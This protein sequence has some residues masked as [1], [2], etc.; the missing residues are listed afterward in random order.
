MRK[1]KAFCFQEQLSRAEIEQ[2][3]GISCCFKRV[4][5]VCISSI[6][7]FTDQRDVVELI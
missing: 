7:D 2:G 5:N 4:H 6:A 3:K 1:D